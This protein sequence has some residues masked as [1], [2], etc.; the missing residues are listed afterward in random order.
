LRDLRCTTLLEDLETIREYLSNR[1]LQPLCLAGS[2][3]GGWAAA[4][5]TRRHPD[6]VPA[7]VLLAPSFD[8]P[9]GLWNRLSEEQRLAWY[10][11][12]QLRVQNEWL[13]AEVDYDLIED[14]GRYPPEEL[15]TGWH[16]PLLIFH[17]MRD[18]V[19]PFSRSVAAVEQMPGAEIEVR[20][21]KNGD[22][23][24]SNLENEIAE[25]ACNFFAQVSPR[26]D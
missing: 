26:A 19:I 8:F 10:Q 7:C 22:H 20:L 5:F 23:R 15:I 1:G 12:G 13:D 11:T 18:E 2:S 9:R 16:T 3:M 6:V 17:G 14:A 24:L 25:G 21:F 4:W